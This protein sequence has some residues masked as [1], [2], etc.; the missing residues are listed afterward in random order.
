MVCDIQLILFPIFVVWVSSHFNFG[1]CVERQ[2]KI[3][4]DLCLCVLL[5]RNVKVFNIVC[6]YVALC[7][8]S[9]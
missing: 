3:Y 4:F 1:L 7:S 9:K 2:P 8:G 6:I 5:C